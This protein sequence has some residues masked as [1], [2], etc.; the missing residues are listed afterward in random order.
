MW[1]IKEES[2]ELIMK[3]LLLPLAGR[4]GLNPKWAHV[5]FTD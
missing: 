5:D 2:K 4:L 3:K 1:I